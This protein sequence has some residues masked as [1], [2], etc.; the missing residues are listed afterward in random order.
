MIAVH[1]LKSATAVTIYCSFSS[2]VNNTFDGFVKGPT[3]ICTGNSTAGVPN[4][5]TSVIGTHQSG[6]SNVN[7]TFLDISVGSQTIPTGIDKYFPNLLH[8]NLMGNTLLEVSPDDLAPFPN[9]QFLRISSNPLTSIDGDLLMNNPGLKHLCINNNKI[10]NVG[11]GILSSLEHLSQVHFSSNT[12]A[13][14]SDTKNSSAVAALADELPE[15][16]PGTLRMLERV[17]HRLQ[18]RVGSSGN[19][20]VSDERIA[21]I[22]RQQTDDLREEI[23]LLHQTS[24]EYEERIDEL[25]KSVRE[26]RS[27]PCA[28]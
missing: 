25:E 17:V 9:L 4:I 20:S 5:V 21:L 15:K 24:R 28:C 2:S 8:I 10:K 27:H 19:G 7:V 23:S 12:C 14:F 18:K 22:V 6:Y 13:T 11:F 26:L 1:N 3:Y 16:C